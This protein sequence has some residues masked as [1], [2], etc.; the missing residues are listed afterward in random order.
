[1]YRILNFATSNNTN[2]INILLFGYGQ[3]LYD[4]KVFELRFTFCNAKYCKIYGIVF[5][6]D[7]SLNAK[8]EYLTYNSLRNNMYG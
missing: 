2:R 1:M 3:F 5:L 6:I 4:V 7:I 8:N